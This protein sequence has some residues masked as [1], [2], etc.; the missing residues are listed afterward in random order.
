MAAAWEKRFRAASIFMAKL[1]TQN[2]S[3]GLVTSNKSGELQLYAW[4]V[5]AGML[6]QLTDVENGKRDGLISPDGRFVYFLQDTKGD[7]KGHWVRV[8]F[9]GGEAECLT[10]DF[11]PYNSWRL[12]QAADGSRLGIFATDG[13]GFTLYTAQT[14]EDGLAQAWQTLWQTQALSMGPF[15]S[16]DGTITVMA[17]TERTKTNRASLIAIDT[18]SAEIIGEQFSPEFGFVPYSFVPRAG[19]S[20]L[21]GTHNESGYH[22]PF[23]WNITTGERTDFPLQS[24][25]GDVHIGD[26]S[27]DSDTLILRQMQN[28]APQLYLLHLG[29]GALERLDHPSGTYLN[30][31]FLD[32]GAICALFED[33]TRP[34]QVVRLDGKSGAL[35]ETLLSAEPVP[36]SRPWRSVT[37]Q[38]TDDATIQAWVATPEGDGPFP[39]ILHTHGGP[40][41]VMPNLFSAESQAWLDHGFAWI[42]VNYRGSVT[43]GKA[44]QQI[45]WGDLGNK[46]IDDIA[47]AYQWLV[48][49]EIALPNAVFLTGG[50]YGG[51]LTLQGLGRRP[52]L[53]AGGMASVAISDW[54]LMY[55]DQSPL[56]RQ[57]QVNLLN[58]TPSENP[59]QYAKSSPITYAEHISAPILVL[60]GKND[61]RCPARQMHVF[62]ETLNKLGKPIHVHWFDAG[63]GSFEMEQ[64][65]EHQHMKLD[66]ALRILDAG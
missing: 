18:H 27:A 66:F 3:R 13:A 57:Y 61:S 28:A 47:A 60:Q 36:A 26:I 63:H 25:E 17:T 14:D 22:R 48:D 55:E 7:E 6:T 59:D 58:G 12:E 31:Q 64:Q 45:I 35:A 50:S 16:H 39:T 54:R 51:Y 43:F 10:P 34:R 52:D 32:D 2:R 46:E 44:Y 23:V 9:E 62:E 5:Q 8:P 11:A 21:I 65:I 20:R 40:D 29:S 30:M 1:A 42:S 41:S 38:S 33:S 53:W 4:D 49:S 56:L 19:E 24:L 15:F 37:F